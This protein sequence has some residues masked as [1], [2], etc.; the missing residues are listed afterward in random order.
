MSAT[1]ARRAYA[2]PSTTTPEQGYD[3]GEIQSPR[4]V[5]MGGAQTATGG[6]TTA[7]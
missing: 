3:L 5:A 1:S 6:S 7:V 4:A 2:D